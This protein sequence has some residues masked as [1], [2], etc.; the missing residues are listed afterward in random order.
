[1]SNAL[2]S[3]LAR[4]DAEG[5]GTFTAD[6]AAVWPAGPVEG[7]VGL[8]LLREAAPAKEVLCLE[9]PEGCW[10]EPRIRDDPRTGKPVGVYFCRRNEEV[11]RFTVDLVRRRRWDFDPAGTAAAVAAAA[12]KAAA[13]KAAALRAEAERKSAAAQPPAPATPISTFST[14]RHD[15]PAA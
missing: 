12:R 8:G 15:R 3:I 5:A 6:E 2:Q 11:G 7:F 9:C 4:A 1:M 13:D 14:S 10:I